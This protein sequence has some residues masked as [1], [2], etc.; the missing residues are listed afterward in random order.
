MFKQQS[1][2]SCTVFLLYFNIVIQD[3]E[4]KFAGCYKILHIKS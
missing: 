4:T 1:F 3:Y 2:F